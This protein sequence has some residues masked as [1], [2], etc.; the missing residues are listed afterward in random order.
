MDEQNQIVIPASFMAIYSRNGRPIETRRTIEERYD[1]CEDLAIQTSEVCQT[2]AF[3]EDLG[4]DE[5][6]TRCRAGI[7]EGDVA[8]PA[9]ADWVIRRTAELLSWTLPASLMPPLSPS[10]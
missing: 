7:V 10:R 4:E 2:L 9:E 6:L 1:F 8:S 5:V 3:K